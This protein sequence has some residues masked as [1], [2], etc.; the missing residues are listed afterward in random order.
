MIL[1]GGKQL[2]RELEEKEEFWT[3]EREREVR[4]R[5]KWRRLGLEGLL[6]VEEPVVESGELERLLQAREACRIV[7]RGL[8]RIDPVFRRLLS[9]YYTDRV[10]PDSIMKELEISRTTFWRW[11]RLAMADLVSACQK[12]PNEIQWKQGS[13]TS[14]LASNR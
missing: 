3:R 6:A 1:K 8:W 7:R 11:R 14:G 12:V 10:A 5:K 13:V 2:E 4:E 9:A